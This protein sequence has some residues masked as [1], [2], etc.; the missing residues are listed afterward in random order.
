MRILTSR[1]RQFAG[2][3]LLTALG[4]GGPVSR[5]AEKA[6]KSADGEEASASEAS[7]PKLAVNSLGM[8]LA[9]I[10]AGEFLMG[11]AERAPG[12]REDEQPQ[13]QVRI[14]KP[15]YLGVY[16]V[17]QGEYEQ[18]MGEN[19]SSFSRAG[20]LKDAPEEL[21]V[22]RLPA[23]NVTWFA[24]IEFCRR[25][26]EMPA[27]KQAG[28]V[29]RL[30]TEAEWEY[31][32]RAG[33]T[34]V[35]AIGDDL[36]S[37]QANFNGKH[38]FGDAEPGPFLNRTATVGSYEPNAFGLYDT[39]GN[40]NEWCLDRFGRDYY[41]YSPSEDPRGPRQGTSRVIRGGDWYSDAR[42]CR[43][44]FRYADI[45]EG[46]FYA[47]GMRVVCELAS[48]GASL[49]PI[50]AAA[51]QTHDAE[52]SPSATARLDDRPMPTSGEEWPQWRGPRGDGSWH[53]PK[54]PAEWPKEGLPRVWRLELGGGYGGVAVADGRAYVMDRQREPDDVERVLCFDAVTGAPL[55]SHAYP[56]NYSDVAYDNGP[57][58]TPTVFEGRAYTLGAVG[59]LLC[60]DAAQGEVIWSHDLVAEYR[61]RVPLWGLSA[62]PVI[63]EDLVIVHPGGE[64]DGC[65]IAF[66]RT[67][68]EERWK[69]LSD[70]AGYAT[71]MLIESH[72]KRQLAAWTPT[73]V[74]GLDPVSGNLLWSVPFEVNYGTSIASPI[75]Q[76]GL[77]LVSSYYEGSLAVRLDD[78]PE[79]AEVVWRDRRNLRGLMMQALYRD[80]YAYLLDKRHGLTCFELSSGKKVWD[81]DNRMT[82]KGRNPQAT[83]VWLNDE[84]RAIALNSDGDLI[85]LR[86]RPEG[87]LE[88]SRTNIIGRT[89][90]HPA[91][92]G[93]CVYARSDSEIVCVVLPSQ[94]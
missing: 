73:H 90:A 72:G 6:A 79:P 56:A 43:S 11:S 85:L 26:S 57:R 12:A 36:S 70:P 66:D 7:L 13:H 45:P 63:F 25:L 60:F 4:C 91:Y 34:T 38:P 29:Y 75:F 67:S 42:D 17:T 84:D 55:W 82:P 24:A 77:L 81:D 51:G 54:L 22:S 20:L 35:F 86:L 14:S 59:Q 31:A 49:D 5:P 74:R 76:E 47:L 19:L 64:D 32:C 23:D 93:N 80:G 71:P 9:L 40:L 3:I 94:D 78:G 39:H 62:S 65:L 30:P 48:Q 2:L 27:E 44:A 52:A 18:V 41:R 15:F 8:K 50:I 87:Y 33:T 89:W 88:E 21:D 37:T 61:A 83:L 92:A 46:R 28:R 10:P 68:G 1:R 69:S 58:S 53:A 16:E